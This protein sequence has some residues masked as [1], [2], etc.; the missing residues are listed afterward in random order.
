MREDVAGREYNVKYEKGGYSPSIDLSGT[1]YTER[2]TFLSAIKWDARMDVRVPLFSGGS[3]MAR[4]S[5]A[6][7]GLKAARLQLE[8]LER[9]VA[10]DVRT[11]HRDLASA[12]DESAALDAAADAAQKSYDTLKEEYTLG[13]V[14]N[15]DVL[16]AMDLLVS[17]RSQA[18]AARLK[19]KRQSFTLAA[20]VEQIP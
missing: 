12:V 5:E 16:Q 13:L 19:A 8:L 10:H 20:A 14:T 1:Y 18:D 11:A 7:A 4:V 9:R 15:L 17:Q 3:V 6:D 2:A